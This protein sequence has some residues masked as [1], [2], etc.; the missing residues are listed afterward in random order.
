M[1]P[2]RH[3]DEAFKAAISHGLLSEDE[4]AD[5]FAGNYMYMGDSESKAMFK[6]TV[7]RAYINHPL[8]STESVAAALIEKGFHV[9][10]FTTPDAANQSVTVIIGAESIKVE[11][12]A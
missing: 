4:S 10:E 7:T 9:S 8:H 6:N 12:Q 11:V 2:Y 5:N 1:I 3:P